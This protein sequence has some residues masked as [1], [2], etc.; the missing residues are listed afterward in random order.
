MIKAFLDTNV[1]I[2]SLE[3]TQ[4]NSHLIVKAAIASNFISV[5]SEPLLDELK[6]YVL[7]NHGTNTADEYLYQIKTIPLLKIIPAYKITNNQEK[8]SKL[9]SDKYDLP[10]ITTCLMEKCN[11]FVT[12]NRKLTKMKAKNKIKFI[13]P[14]QFIEELGLPSLNTKDEE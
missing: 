2:V 7:R 4:T 3:N 14:K 8:Y 11:C 10:H 6:E 5:I 12:L 9:V 13:S 1:F